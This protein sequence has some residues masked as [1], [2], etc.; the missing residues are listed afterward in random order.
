M[1]TALEYLDK[2]TNEVSSITS[3]LLSYAGPNWRNQTNME[4]N[5][6]DIKITTIRLKMNLHKFVDFSEGC[7]GNAVNALDKGELY[8]LE[9]MMI[10][11][12]SL[13]L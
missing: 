9:T 8:L 12:D 10:L 11:Y 3:R 7:L 1:N 2:L 13:L 6:T 4:S 5:L